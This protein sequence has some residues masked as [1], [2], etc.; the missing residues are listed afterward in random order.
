MIDSIKKLFEIK[1][2][3]VVVALGNVALRLGHRL[4][5]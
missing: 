5:S 1:V 2:D 3:H 4:M